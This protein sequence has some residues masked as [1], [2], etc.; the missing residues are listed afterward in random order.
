MKIPSI[1]LLCSFVVLVGAAAIPPTPPSAGPKVNYVKPG[2]GYDASI[3][4]RGNVEDGT[5]LQRD[6]IPDHLERRESYWKRALA[7]LQRRETDIQATDRLLFVEPIAA[8][9]DARTQE[10]P[11]SLDWS[12]D[13]CSDSP[14]HP[15]KFNFLPSCQRHDFGYRN[16]K[17]QNRFTNDSKARI[18]QNFK[19]DMHNECNKYSVLKREAC[20][21]V[22]DF[23]YEAVKEFG[24][25]L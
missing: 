19:N 24:S 11:P 3:K 12:S 17:K 4:P 21:G 20:K 10:N 8:F 7:F 1:L 22:A 2:H 6:E 16:Y 14:D 13:G 5:I 23:Y 15:I 25:K 18:D 9:L